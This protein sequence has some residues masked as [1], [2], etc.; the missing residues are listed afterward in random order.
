LHLYKNNYLRLD[1]ALYKYMLVQKQT[2]YFH[3]SSKE[4]GNW[5]RGW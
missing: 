3:C 2:P 5:V 4:K 1:D